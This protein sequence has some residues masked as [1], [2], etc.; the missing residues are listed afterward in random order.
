MRLAANA[1]QSTLDGA[2]GVPSRRDLADAA[3]RAT[4]VALFTLLAVRLGVDFLETG[5]LTG[6][7]LLASEALVVVLTV[8]RRAPTF[9]DRSLR[10]RALTGMSLLGP[11]VVAPAS[12]APIAAEWVTVSLSASGLLVVIG[13]KISL[14]RSFGLMPANRGIVCTGLYHVVRHPIYMGYLITHVAFVAANPTTWNLVALLSAD[15]ALMARAVCEEET[16]A[17]DPE[18]RR[19]QQRVR[20]RVIPGVF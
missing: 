8:F 17:R 6:L 15:L 7:L 10:A 1:G 4:I 13:G 18:Y 11:L 5:R 19:Y 12:A 14:G 3:A 9:V 20:W 2:L 16:L